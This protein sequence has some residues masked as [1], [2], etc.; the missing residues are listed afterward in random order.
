M[1]DVPARLR[2]IAYEVGAI[3]DF[4]WH[5]DR[6]QEHIRHLDDLSKR[7]FDLATELDEITPS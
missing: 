3:P 6:N 1:S 2:Q 5:P 7:L 4:L